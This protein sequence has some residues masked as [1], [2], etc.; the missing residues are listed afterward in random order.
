[1][2]TV[3]QF[4]D[5]NRGLEMS[6][7]TCAAVWI[8]ATAVWI[9][10]L[11][12]APL[13]LAGGRRVSFDFT[14]DFNSLSP[15][16]YQ[17][18]QQQSLW[19]DWHIASQRNRDLGPN[20]LFQ[21]VAAPDGNAL[22]AYYPAGSIGTTVGLPGY[23]EEDWSTSWPAVPTIN[24]EFYLVFMPGFDFNGSQGKVFR[25]L[26]GNYELRLMWNYN[27]VAR[28]SVGAH[29]R[30]YTG[31]VATG[32]HFREGNTAYNIVPGQVYDVH[33]WLAPGSSG[34]AG[35][36]IDGVS[37]FKD[38]A[39]AYT[40]GWWTGNLV[41]DHNTFFGGGGSAF[42]ALS[43]QVPCYTRLVR[44]IRVWGAGGK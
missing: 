17:I 26:A 40:G 15:G 5:K 22:Q 12:W 14:A 24:V 18:S 37:F 13:A 41:V 30:A 32:Q 10:A 20:L 11:L 1:M 8:A 6:K 25:L 34:G 35:V 29:F 7:L 43:A 36:D 44:S 38:T 4:A 39:H 3:R 9:A 42:S 33:M 28:T 21:I 19:T 2:R 16:P 23:G 27:G 31:D